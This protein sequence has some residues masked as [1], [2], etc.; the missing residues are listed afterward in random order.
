MRT[1]VVGSLAITL[2]IT[3]SIE[4]YFRQTTVASDH[5]TSPEMSE[6]QESELISQVNYPYRSRRQIGGTGRRE[7]LSYQPLNTDVG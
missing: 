1:L 2:V 6:F 7:I 4:A 5:A 3:G